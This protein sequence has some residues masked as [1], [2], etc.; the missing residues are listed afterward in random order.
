MRRRVLAST[1]AERID[2]TRERSSMAVIEPGDGWL[3][4]SEESGA[5][6]QIRLYQRSRDDSYM[7]IVEYPEPGLHSACTQTD[8][9][10][11]QLGT[12]TLI[13]SFMPDHELN[14]L[15]TLADDYTD[16]TL[17]IS[18]GDDGKYRASVQYMAGGDVYRVVY[19][20]NTG[21]VAYEKQPTGWVDPDVLAL[22][23]LKFHVST[24]LAG[25]YLT[26]AR[27]ILSSLNKTIDDAS[28]ELDK[29]DAGDGF[30]DFLDDPSGDAED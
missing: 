15:I 2:Q 18:A 19:V 21:A 17:V 3:L 23:D 7:R 28:A 8:V 9:Y 27:A 5:G 22:T 16:M 14:E 24:R 1:D 4:K 11:P 25:V 6:V 29:L 26:T 12:I 13:D 10:T 30:Y 20:K